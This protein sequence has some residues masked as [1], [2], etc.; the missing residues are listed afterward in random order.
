MRKLLKIV[1]ILFMG[2]NLHAQQTVKIGQLEGKGN[3]FNSSETKLYY[4]V[5]GQGDPL[6]ILHGNGGSVKGKYNVIPQLAE[7]YK[8]IAVDSRC[9]G[10]SGCPDGDLTYEAMA[11]DIAELIAH[12]KL[13]NV[14]IWG[15]SDGGIIGL[16]LGYTH[17][18]GIKNMLISGANLRPDSTALEPM[19]VRFGLR[20]NEIQ[21]PMMRKHVKLLAE[22]PNID[23]ANLLQVKIPVMLL[24]GDRDAVLMSHTMEIFNA[25][26]MVNLCV[27][28]AT[29]HFVGS[30]K[31]NH[32]IY[33]LKEMKKPFSAP[34]TV[35]V[36]E[37][38]ARQIF[39]K[40]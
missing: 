38:M 4:E 33:W 40:K 13:E 1:V 17:P 3:Y 28:P 6:L 27:L 18:A 36:A 29:S 31:P 8:V 10:Q 5:F 24:V 26:P 30:E 19:L 9:H 39:S 35:A 14:T 11:K 2:W 37:E 23:P 12:L 7:H 20:Y 32:I 21:D 15:H 16:I 22:H 25:L 34:S